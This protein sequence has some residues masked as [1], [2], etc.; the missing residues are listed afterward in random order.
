METAKHRFV[1]TFAPYILG[2][3]S[4]S[5]IMHN[6]MTALVPAIV[7]GLYYFRGDAFWVMAFAVVTA[8]ICEAGMQRFL[9]REVTTSDGS[10]ALSGL[11]LA[12]LLAS[13]TPWWV[14]V[15]GTGFVIIIGKQIY[16]G[17]GNNP[18]NDVLVGWVVL[19]LS[20]P[21]QISDWVE[22]YGSEISD[23]PLYAFKSDGIEGFMDSDFEFLD[24]FLGVQAGGIGS[25]CIAALLAGGIY[26][27]IRRIIS[28]HIPVGLLGAVFIFSWMLWLS[29]SE[30]YI[31]PLFHLLTGSTVLGAFFIATDPATSPVTW[32]AKLAFGILCGSLI[33]VIRT[34]GDYP[35]GVVFAI[36]L[37]NA[38]A[39]L[40][41]KIK[42][43]PYGKEK[44]VA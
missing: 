20:W 17:L 5:D 31:H 15:I 38:S 13:T 12:L 18:F 27:L 11:L 25:I 34:W 10:A 35:D 42:P 21:E 4:V 40:L 24:L 32:W 19:R 16:G 43:R 8:I 39:P 44:A 9:G 30:V 41:S 7:A 29:D 26:L 23:S 14:V 22:P 1:V 28:W 36:L 3:K 33:M 6:K 37:A 2:G